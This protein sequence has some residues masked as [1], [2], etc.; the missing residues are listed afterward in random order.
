MPRS[1]G[2]PG[3]KLSQIAAQMPAT[4]IGVF[5]KAQIISPIAVMNAL[6]PSLI[7]ISRFCDTQPGRPS[8]IKNAKPTINIL[9][10]ECMSA[11][12]KT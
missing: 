1:S 5:N 6:P 7:K 2:V 4:A 11:L 3:I 12:N 10:C 9:R 8:A